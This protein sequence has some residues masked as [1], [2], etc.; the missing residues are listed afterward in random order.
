MMVDVWTE[1]FDVLP[2]DGFILKFPPNSNLMVL[3]EEYSALNK[4]K[5]HPRLTWKHF[6]LKG[7]ILALC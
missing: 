4:R 3:G 5:P 6:V 7:A 1:T 2:S